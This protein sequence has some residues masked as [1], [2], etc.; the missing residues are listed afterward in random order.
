MDLQM[1]VLDGLEAAQ[2]ILK[3]AQQE[4]RIPPLVVAVT[5]NIF[6]EHREQCRKVGMDGF[7]SKPLSRTHLREVLEPLLSARPEL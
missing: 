6:E 2:R 4:G 7:L 3:H 5:A 1:P